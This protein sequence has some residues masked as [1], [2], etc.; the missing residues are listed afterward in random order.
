MW[1]CQLGFIR[2]IIRFISLTE[3]ELGI[4]QLGEEWLRMLIQNQQFKVHGKQTLN[5]SFYFI[6]NDPL[7]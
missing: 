6:S 3:K 2:D 7:D 1:C 5:I 4:L